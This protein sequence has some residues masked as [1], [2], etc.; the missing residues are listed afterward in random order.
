[1]AGEKVL[2][3]VTELSSHPAKITRVVTELTIYLF[4]NMAVVTELT[5][6]SAKM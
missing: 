6:D 5:G 2:T 4:I 1:M 3:A